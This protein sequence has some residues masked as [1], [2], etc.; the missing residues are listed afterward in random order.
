MV[1]VSTQQP[2]CLVL[3]QRGDEGL[4]FTAIKISCHKIEIELQYQYVILT[5]YT[6]ENQQTHHVLKF[7][8]T[9]KILKSFCI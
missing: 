5:F 6:N 7:S 4:F 2:S 3:S 9:M 1:V 8:H